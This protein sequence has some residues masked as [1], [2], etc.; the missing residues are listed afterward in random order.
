MTKKMPKEKNCKIKNDKRK[1]M[2]KDIKLF[3]QK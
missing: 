2:V 3:T 1:K